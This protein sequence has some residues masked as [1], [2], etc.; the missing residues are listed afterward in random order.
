MIVSGP[1][2]FDKPWSCSSIVDKQA[3]EIIGKLTQV[4]KNN[5]KGASLKSLAL[6]SHI[7]AKQATYKVAVETIKNLKTI[8]KLLAASKILEQNP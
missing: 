3:A 7:Q 4:R 5:T 8:K 2:G 1:D 6:A